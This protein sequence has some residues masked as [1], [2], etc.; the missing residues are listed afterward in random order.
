MGGK[1]KVVDGLKSD[2]RVA[3]CNRAFTVPKAS[4]VMSRR[5][6]LKECSEII[7][8]SLAM[9]RSVQLLNGRQL[10]DF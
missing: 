9:M 8:D 4:D 5:T 7:C 3:S 1:N 2:L 10:Y 6:S